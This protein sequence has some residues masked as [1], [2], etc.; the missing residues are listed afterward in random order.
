MATPAIRRVVR[1][2]AARL[3]LIL[4][5]GLSLL[6]GLGLRQ[7]DQGLTE[8]AQIRRISP[9]PAYPESPLLTA[10]L[11]KKLLSSSHCIPPFLL[12]VVIWQRP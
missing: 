9:L 10:S 7:A 8:L 2:S 12:P 11:L 3:L 4:M 1:A 5:L 6:F